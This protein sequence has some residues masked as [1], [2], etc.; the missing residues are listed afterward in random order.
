[1]TEPS[2]D[3]SQENLSLGE[4]HSVIDSERFWSWRQER[5]FARNIQKGKP[6][7]NGPSSEPPSEK[8]NPS[9]LLQCHRKVYYKSK[10]APGE[11][12]EPAG[13]FWFGSEFETEFAVPFL[14]D[15][16]G[17]DQF[18]RNSMWVDYTIS[19]DAGQVSIRGETDP[20]KVN[21]PARI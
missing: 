4:F 14:R 9:R 12:R 6:Y 7:F 5:E 8:H 2:T 20:V 17:P 18:V 13:I 16:V 11:Q 3:T 10:N 15:I 19:T 1:M 21:G